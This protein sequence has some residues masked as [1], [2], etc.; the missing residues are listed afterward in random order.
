MIRV[1]F[2]LDDDEEE[3]E[4][5]ERLPPFLSSFVGRSSNAPRI[6]EIRPPPTFAV[7]HLQRRLLDWRSEIGV[8]SK[9]VSHKSLSESAGWR[10]RIRP[11]AFPGPIPSDLSR[12]KETAPSPKALI[13]A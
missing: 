2:A 5:V 7:R 3:E 6:F 11:S 12:S 10:H 13:R 1:S 8:R 9:S 4:E